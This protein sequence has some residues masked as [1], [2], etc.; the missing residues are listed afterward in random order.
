MFEREVRALEMTSV[1]TVMGV[2]QIATQQWLLTQIDELTNTKWPTEYANVRSNAHHD[3]VLDAL[4][5]IIYFLT[6]IA[7][8]I[9]LS[10]LNRLDLANPGSNPLL[11][12]RLRGMA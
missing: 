4:K 1:I 10:D 12:A 7:N 3:Y 6:I 5:Q 2:G 11:T 8:R 9:F